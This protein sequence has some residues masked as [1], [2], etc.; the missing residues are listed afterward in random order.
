LGFTQRAR[1]AQRYRNTTK[2]LPALLPGGCR[3]L[4]NASGGQ[5]PT[6]KSQKSHHRK[7]S[8]LLCVRRFAGHA[9][10]KPAWYNYYQEIIA[11]TFLHNNL[12]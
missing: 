3:G 2:V 1:R 12:P 8:N 9:A 11:E 5:Q 10:R 6:K 4:V 7:I